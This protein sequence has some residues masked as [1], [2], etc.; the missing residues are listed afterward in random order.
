MIMRIL[1]WIRSWFGI[2]P[3]VLDEQAVQWQSDWSGLLLEHV[4]FYRALSKEDR[5]VFEQRCLLFINSTRI[6]AGAFE[7]NDIDRLLVAASAVIPVWGFPNWHYFNLEAVFLLP[8]LF[9][10]AFECG[11]EDSFYSGMVGTG[12]MAGKMALSR[13]HL[14]LGFSNELDKS[15]VGVHEFVHLVDMM[16]GVCDGVPERLHKFHSV[17]TWVDFVQNKMDE[18]ALTD[19]GIRDY[20]AF[21]QQEFLA[22]ASEFFFER[23]KLLA[24]K[25]PRL[26]EL[27]SRFYK[28]NMK[29][30]DLENRLR[31]KGPCPC[32]SGKRYKRCCMPV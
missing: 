4:A 17:M 12:P 24:R 20:G 3:K 16:D 31:K 11:A 6:E 1:N 27:L 30:M 7:V 2:H 13:P 8:G 14:H 15:N 23:P 22:V 25:H 19:N 9:N 10:D 29:E 5:L 18:I 26:Y 32:G 21:N 28:Q